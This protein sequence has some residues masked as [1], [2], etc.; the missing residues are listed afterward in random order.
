MRPDPLSLGVQSQIENRLEQAGDCLAVN[1]LLRQLLLK[2]VNGVFHLDFN[3]RVKLHTSG[4]LMVALG[5]KGDTTIPF[6]IRGTGSSPSFVPDV[7]GIASE[8]VNS[9]LKGE[10]PAKAAKELIEGFFGRKKTK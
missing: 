3:M 10:D 9:F 4:N 6:F 7:K 2:P 5:Q 1:R 8:K